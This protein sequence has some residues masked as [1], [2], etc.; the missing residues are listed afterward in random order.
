MIKHLLAALLPVVAFA[1]EQAQPQAE[2]PATQETA[3]AP[4]APVTE[5]TGV[6]PNVSGSLEFGYRWNGDLHGN[7][8]AYRTV[9][10][11]GKGPRLLGFDFR[12]LNPTRGRWLDSINV[13]ASGWGGDPYSSVR[14]E[15]VTDGKYR[16]SFDHRSMAYF[17]ALPSFANPDVQR[18]ILFSQN[19]Y[20]IFHRLTDIDLEL[21]PGT[22]IIP[23]FGY[24]RNRN[25]GGGVADY[26]TTYNEYPVA[27]RIEDSTNNFRGGVRFETSRFHVTLEQGG[28]TFENNQRLFTS[29]PNSGNRNTPYL[30]R[31]LFLNNLAQTYDITG[32]S[33]YSKV[34]FTGRPIDWIDVYAN[35][36]YAQPKTEGNLMS[37]AQGNFVQG[38]TAFV[39]TE[40]FLIVSTAKQPHTSA[41][42][43]FELRPF[44]RV[45]ILESFLT[46]RF[47][48][49]G[50]LVSPTV[51]DDRL[52][53]NYNQ[54]LIELLFDITPRLTV[55]G[56]HKY[57]W[58]DAVTRA[59][60]LAMDFRLSQEGKLKT[61]AGVGGITY[62]FTQKLSAY[63]DFEVGR[64]DVVYF[65]T[66]V[67]DY[68]RVRLRGSYQPI[69]TLTL[70][71]TYSYFHNDNPGSDGGY[72]FDSRN[73][74]AGFIWTPKSSKNMR[75]VG[76]YGRTTF[77]S[78]TM[79]I[80]PTDLSARERSFYRDNGHSGTAL[81]ELGVPG[82]A[83][84]PRVT[85]GGSM[86]RS[87]G[88]R[89]SHFYQP[90]VRLAVPV[91]PHM[92]LNGEWRWYGLN[93]P[94]YRYEN[95]R[96]H[97]AIFSVRLK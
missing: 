58:G 81:I 63:A 22:R 35:F 31:T 12:F 72:R 18:G 45:R 74:S 89:P 88:S 87:T 84:S 94:Y 77:W 76:E 80:V 27:T 49:S 66:G 92:E 71:G 16:L 56:G 23:F 75:F 15:L 13:R 85:F 40:Q 47:H 70:T 10:N 61:H 21:R 64:S 8:D 51:F 9:V 67:R 29:D 46:D 93:E 97:Q 96:Q 1:Q 43:G 48:T 26:Q 73:T 65:R 24:M 7:L 2:K 30:G 78:D 41:N 6:E 4:A 68:E 17:N 20:D 34:L 28:T 60:L 3:A 59:P 86:W 38:S 42:G 37:T 5:Q 69:S 36:L 91:M 50:S 14:G 90:V 52:V 82:L 33:I 54:Q 44:R 55:R 25:T 32:S 57:V 95:F 53:V 62:R 83:Y 39:P 11:L 19:Q 79:Y